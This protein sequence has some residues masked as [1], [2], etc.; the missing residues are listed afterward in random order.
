MA[1]RSWRLTQSNSFA[2]QYEDKKTKSL[3]MLPADM[4]LVQDKAMKPWVEKY[5]RDNDLFF[6]DFQAVITKL[7]ELGV[8]FAEGS[9]NERMVFKR[10]QE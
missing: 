3:M 9:E 7:F 2:V 10:T 8:P 4:A 1:R 6:K 5:A